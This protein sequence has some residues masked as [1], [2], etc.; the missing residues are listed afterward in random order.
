MP[1]LRDPPSAFTGAQLEYLREVARAI[2]GLPQWSYFTQASPNGV[3]FGATGDRAV[4]VGS[5]STLSRE[6][7]KASEPGVVSTTS[8]VQLRVQA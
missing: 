7:V 6:W 3:L 2:R 5:T 4:Y 8:W 1:E